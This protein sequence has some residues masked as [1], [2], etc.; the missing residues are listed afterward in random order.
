MPKKYGKKLSELNLGN[1]TPSFGKYTKGA[2][3]RD[4]LAERDAD[5]SFRGRKGDDALYFS[6]RVREVDREAREGRIAPGGVTISHAEQTV[7]LSLPALRR[8]HFPV[9]GEYKPEFDNAARTVLAALGLVRGDSC[10]GSRSR[11][12]ISLPALARGTADLEPSGQAWRNACGSG[13]RRGDGDPATRR[14]GEEGKGSRLALAERD[15][16]THAV[17]LTRQGRRRRAS[18]CWPSRAARP[19]KEV[20]DGITGD[21]LGIPHGLRGGY[22]PL[23]PRSSGVAAA[24]GARLHGARGSLVRDRAGRHR[25]RRPRRLDGRR[26]G[27]ALAGDTRRS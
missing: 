19:A 12:A 22:R 3:G 2:E 25:G 27:L 6:A 20:T 4:P 18:N 21:C 5:L 23:Y 13:T 14:G 1:V 24:P 7:V 9:G 8:L 15:Y 11:P 17:G 10:G 26:G 16:R